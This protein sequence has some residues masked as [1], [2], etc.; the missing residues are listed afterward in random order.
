MN[1][2]RTT[3]ATYSIVTLSLIAAITATAG[4]LNPPPGPVSPTGP[5]LADLQNDI[6]NIMPGSGGA[7]I[8][9][10]TTVV[11]GAT[12]DINA[13]TNE[14]FASLIPRGESNFEVYFRADTLVGTSTEMAYT[15]YLEVDSAEI[16]TETVFIP[17][18]GPGGGSSAPLISAIRIKSSERA[19]RNTS[20]LFAGNTMG[21]NVSVDVAFAI[22]AASAI[23]IM[24][25]S[26]DESYITFLQINETGFEV[27]FTP[28]AC[29]T[30]TTTDL[31][32]AGQI[33][34]TLSTS[35]NIQTNEPCN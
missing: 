10:I 34:G 20:R 24:E 1:R 2:S 13:N 32:S 25:I 23:E 30:V 21:T 28:A 26:L 35:W 16:S 27:E 12:I 5:S 8:G 3:A 6:N 7:S 14:G 31:G 33:L 19:D 17:G 22:Q 15:D 9:Q 18:P 29:V 4:D 11:D